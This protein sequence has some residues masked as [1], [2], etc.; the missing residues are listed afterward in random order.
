MTELPFIIR[1]S[2]Q[3]AG[4]MPERVDASGE[5]GEDSIDTTG[6]ARSTRET[7]VRQE[8]TDDE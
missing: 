7:R 3:L 8:T 2:E 1:Y 4:S 5:H 6:R